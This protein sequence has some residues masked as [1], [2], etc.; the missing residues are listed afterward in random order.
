MTVGS[1]GNGQRPAGDAEHVPIQ[2][3]N[4]GQS[5][6]QAV[7]DQFQGRFTPVGIRGLACRCL[8]PDARRLLVPSH[9]QGPGVA[10]RSRT[11][12]VPR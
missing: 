7:D 11:R 9:G 6:Q 12:R 1:G 8:S 5:G 4:E 2:G 10:R 3:H